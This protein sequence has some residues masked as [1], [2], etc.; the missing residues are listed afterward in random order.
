MKNVFLLKLSTL[1]EHAFVPFGEGWRI[2]T[3]DL[4]R[5]AFRVSF[6][7]HGGIMQRKHLRQFIETQ[8]FESVR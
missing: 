5:Q 2:E 8:L 7:I 6:T 4:S 1:G 3:D